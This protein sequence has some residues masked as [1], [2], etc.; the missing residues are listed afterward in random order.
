LEKK[1]SAGGDSNFS[2]AVGEMGRRGEGGEADE[3]SDGGKDEAVGEV[4]D[5]EEWCFHEVDARR[6]GT[7]AESVK[8]FSRSEFGVLT[9]AATR[10]GVVA[11]DVSLPQRA[12]QVPAPS[13]SAC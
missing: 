9:P 5:V 6:G 12:S 2:A 10:V 1:G 13:S 7:C 8:S 11:E 3:E 4:H